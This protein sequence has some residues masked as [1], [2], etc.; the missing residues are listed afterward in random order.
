MILI[1]K[2]KNNRFRLKIKSY[3]KL[4]LLNFLNSFNFEFNNPYTIGPFMQP[5]NKK[6]FCVLRSPFSN[7]DSRDHFELR[8]YSSTFIC[9]FNNYSNSLKFIRLLFK[10]LSFKFTN[11]IFISLEKY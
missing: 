11:N 3:N 2:N 7:K 4:V 5:Q 8:L 6:V 1:S 10:K 9:R